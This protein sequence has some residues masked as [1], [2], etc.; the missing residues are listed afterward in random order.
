M[1]K[2]DQ[3]RRSKSIKLA[4]IFGVVAVLWYVVSMLV[5]WTQ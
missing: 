1:E 3:A 5:I 2:S 4:L